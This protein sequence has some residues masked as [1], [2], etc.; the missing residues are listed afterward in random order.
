[1]N[2]PSAIDCIELAHSTDA[3][4]EE[5]TLEAFCGPTRD[6]VRP[7]WGP[8]GAGLLLNIYS[9]KRGI[10][11]GQA[12]LTVIKEERCLVSANKIARHDL[13]SPLGPGISRG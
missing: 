2:V 5:Q 3:I 12:A 11:L 4:I 8:E 1:M 6:D 9:P 7:A 13:R 10:E